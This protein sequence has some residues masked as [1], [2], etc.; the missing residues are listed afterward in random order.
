MIQT[1]NLSEIER[2]YL[3]HPFTQMQD[4]EAEEPL[5]IESAQGVYLKGRD[6]RT[7]Y[8]GNSSMWLNVHGHC[9]P[10]LNQAIID[11]LG[12]AAHTTL[13]GLTHEPAARL[14][15]RLV[16]IAPK[17]RSADPDRDLSRVFYSDDGSTAVEVA[18]KMA[19]Q[20]WKQSDPAGG[21]SHYLALSEGYHGDTIGAVS[22]G[23]I[24]RFHS[25]FQSLLFPV[26]FIG[27]PSTCKTAAEAIVPLQKALEEEPGKYFAFILEPRVQLAG[28]VL[29][30]PDGYLKLVREVC[31][32]YGVLL[33]ADEVATGFGRTGTMFACEQDGI[34][35]DFLCLGKGITGGYLPLAAT[36][37]TPQI[38]SA[39]LADYTEW[40]SFTH[41]HSYTGN[42][43]ACAAALA[44]LDLFEQDSLIDTL[45]PKIA[46]MS[47]A[48]TRFLEL[49][50][51]QEIRQCGMI[52][53]IV[54]AKDKANGIDYAATDAIGPHVCRKARERGLITRSLG[55]VITLL[56]PLV[57]TVEE[58]DAMLSI[59]YAAVIEGTQ[60]V[61]AN[62]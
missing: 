29:V 13:L 11:Q 52:A 30:Q 17:S 37:T 23:K 43:L 44:S 36:L 56:P 15:E 39:F 2:R 58:I 32:K 38:Y 59:L 14:A 18:L 31:D 35:P 48:L 7:Y 53:G 16:Q 27:S 47:A 3:W 8:D 60:K 1:D 54:L 22:V 24:G 55:S 40:K 19:Y 51:V 34:A 61:Q 12:K 42:P 5:F 50:H 6:G 62:A 20:Y 10:E 9:R 21:R 49:E 45:A 26:D 41:G 33:I 4:W 46:F 25:I 28:G 57:S